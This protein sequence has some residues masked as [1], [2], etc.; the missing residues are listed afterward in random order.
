MTRIEAAHSI[1]QEAAG[2]SA[3]WAIG[4]GELVALDRCHVMGVLNV[5][6]DSFSDGGRYS[7]VSD[8][9]GRAVAMV[10]EGA[11]MIDVGGES[12]RPGAEQVDPREQVRRVVPVIKGIRQCFE[13]PISIDTTSAEVAEAAIEAGASIINDVSAGMDDPGLLPLAAERACGLILMHRLR[14]PADDSWSDSY[15]QAPDYGNVVNDV[16]GALNALVAGALDAG[17][18]ADAIAIDP[19]LGFGKSVAQNY[20]LIGAVRRFIETGFPVLCAA[21]RKSFIGA[22]TGQAE[23]SQRVAGSV[24]IACWQAF[25]GVRLFRVHDVASHVRALAAIDRV[26]GFL[27]GTG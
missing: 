24:A 4:P 8:A 5:T 21:S 25:N 19:G 17:V 2:G 12:T 13:V 7:S 23:P 16:L 9:I 10:D 14:P 20:Q 1:P 11:G 18:R 26:N 15:E 27:P 3:A 6:P 22:V